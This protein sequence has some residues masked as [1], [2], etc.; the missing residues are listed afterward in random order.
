MNEVQETLERALASP[1]RLRFASDLE[2]KLWVFRAHNFI[3]RHAPEL[4]QLMIS[5]RGG[6]I[7][8]RVPSFSVEEL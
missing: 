8:L 1:L 4:R 6:E 3:R 7:T 5:R 2:A